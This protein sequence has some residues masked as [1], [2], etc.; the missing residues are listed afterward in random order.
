MRSMSRPVIATTRSSSAT[1]FFE[2]SNRFSTR[3]S[4][5]ARIAV[6]SS[7][8]ARTRPARASR[9]RRRPFSSSA[10]ASARWRMR[11]LALRS[12]CT[13]SSSVRVRAENASR[14]FLKNLPCST[15]A[16][17]F[18]LV[19]REAASCSLMSRSC[20][21]SLSRSTR[22]LVCSPSESSTSC[23]SAFSSPSSFELLALSSCQLSDSALKAA[24]DSASFWRSA[25]VIVSAASGLNCCALP[26]TFSSSARLFA[27]FSVRSLKRA[28]NRST[29]PMSSRSLLRA[30][31]SSR[32][33]S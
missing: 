33:F 21:V 2:R 26:A 6:S 7:S 10:F 29:S 25:G 27:M 32:F 4:C 23:A 8:R 28:L 17:S 1:P 20:M 15:S 31:A 13:S 22:S 5:D 18:S 24:I 12:D 19:A 16:R 30:I 14:S 3:R 11:A 9:S